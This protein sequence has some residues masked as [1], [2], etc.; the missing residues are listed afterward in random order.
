MFSPGVDPQST[1]LLQRPVRWPFN[2]TD[3]STA[4]SPSRCCQIYTS[5]AKSCCC[6]NQHARDTF[7]AQLSTKYHLHVVSTDSPTSVSMA[8]H[9]HTCQPLFALS[10]LSQCALQKSISCLSRES[11]Q[12][13]RV[14][15]GSTMLLQPWN[16]LPPL[17]RDPNTTLTDFRLMP[18][19]V[20]F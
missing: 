15:V 10:G 1:R 6:A 16:A 8:W 2:R 18:K 4:V 5:A 13:P 7:L 19:T 17:L 12:P 11:A 20:L 14:L 3:G 9:L